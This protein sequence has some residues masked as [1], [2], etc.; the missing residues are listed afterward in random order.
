VKG[1]WPVSDASTTVLQGFLE[2]AISGDGAGPASGCW[3]SP[4]TA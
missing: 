3:N 1:A 2:R 4:A